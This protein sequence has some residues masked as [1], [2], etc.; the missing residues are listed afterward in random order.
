MMKELT[1]KHFPM[2]F[3]DSVQ[4]CTSCYAV[5]LQRI[6]RERFTTLVVTEN[7]ETPVQTGRVVLARTDSV[8]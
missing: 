5:P 7:P 8:W 3:V 4:V 6:F 1:P 2:W